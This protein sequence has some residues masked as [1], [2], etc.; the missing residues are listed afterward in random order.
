MPA[1]WIVWLNDKQCLPGLVL[2]STSHDWSLSLHCIDFMSSMS[3]SEPNAL[4]SCSIPDDHVISYANRF[5]SRVF[6][7]NFQ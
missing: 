4:I 1:D 5:S 2:V 3:L 6:M 7:I